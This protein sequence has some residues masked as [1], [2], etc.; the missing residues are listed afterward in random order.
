MTYFQPLTEKIGQKWSTFHLEKGQ[1][2][3]IFDNFAE[4]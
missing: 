2:L 4:I 3:V 1:K